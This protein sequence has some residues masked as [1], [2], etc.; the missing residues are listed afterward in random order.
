MNQVNHQKQLPGKTFSS[1]GSLSEPFLALVCQ[2]QFCV[3]IRCRF[4]LRTQLTAALEEGVCCA[5]QEI[6]EWLMRCIVI[7]LVLLLIAAQPKQTWPV[8]Q[9]FPHHAQLY[10]LALKFLTFSPSAC[11]FG[12]FACRSPC[13]FQLRKLPETCRMLPER[14]LVRSGPQTGDE[15]R[16]C[17]CAQLRASGFTLAARLFLPFSTACRNAIANAQKL[18]RTPRTR[19][20]HP[21]S[22]MPK[23]RVL[24]RELWNGCSQWARLP[25]PTPR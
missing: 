5:R 23:L 21:C 16:T 19:L 3:R 12:S 13:H 10:T 9:D 24:H 22:R 11:T 14:I 20:L 7:V 6:F 15:R 25:N 17:T 8:Y 4:S 1:R 2:A 18:L